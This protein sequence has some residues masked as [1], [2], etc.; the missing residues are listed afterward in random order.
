MSNKSKNRQAPSKKS[1]APY[2]IGIGTDHIPFLFGASMLRLSM[3]RLMV[4][5]VNRGLDI[6]QFKNCQCFNDY[7][8]RYYPEDLCS[9]TQYHKDTPSMYFINHLYFNNSTIFE[10]APNEIYGRGEMGHLGFTSFSW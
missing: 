1:V 10:H 9:I 6:G 7:S 3:D 5:Q 4:C 2:K 8:I